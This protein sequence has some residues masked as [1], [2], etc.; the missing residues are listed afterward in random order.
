MASNK[1]GACCLKVVYHEGEAKGQFKQIAGL[2]SYQ[3]GEKFG[4]E[5]IIVILTD[6]YG[7]KLPN[8]A[9]LADQ[10]SEMSCRQVLIP[11]ILMGEPVKS[12]A[13]EFPT[14]IQKHSP[15]IT[16]SIVDGFLA[17][18]TKEKSPKSLF[19]IGYCFGAKFCIQ[20]LAKDGY[21]TAAAVAHPSF[22]TIEEV[23]AV[24]KP[25]LISA[26]ETDPI[27]TEELR[28]KTIETLAAN[29]A[30]YQY[31]LF[32]GVSHGFA[33]KGDLSIPQVKYAKEKVLIDQVYFFSQF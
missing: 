22:V 27:F 14:W 15:E 17:Q 29:K 28:N 33:V 3:T 20:N 12:Y 11:D 32:L 8:V 19:G 5:E 4:D 2:D 13:D 10:L 9:L 7:Y 16:R 1:P 21:F 24:T 18:L 23:D 26:A 31:D 25:I 6:I 30:T